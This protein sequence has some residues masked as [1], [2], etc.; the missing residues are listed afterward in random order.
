MADAERKEQ[1]PIAGRRELLLNVASVLSHCYNGTYNS[2][3][4]LE[5]RSTRLYSGFERMNARGFR[6]AQ[7]HLATATAEA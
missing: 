1:C 4:E 5:P 3:I 6:S 7:L 2:A